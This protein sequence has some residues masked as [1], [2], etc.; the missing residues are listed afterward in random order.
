LL[1]KS[2]YFRY[3]YINTKGV[4]GEDFV[5]LLSFVK[6]FNF[7]LCEIGFKYGVISEASEN[8]IEK[9]NLMKYENISLTRKI[10]LE[11]DD[12]QMIWNSICFSP[13]RKI[14]FD[15]D[16]KY[17]QISRERNFPPFYKKKIIKIKPQK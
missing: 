7:G 3:Y 14:N 11:I 1:D 2:E 4:S 10:D 17:Y 9:R 6:N 16:L 13:I 15:E 8:F 5:T 12:C